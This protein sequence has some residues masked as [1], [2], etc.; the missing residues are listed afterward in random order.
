MDW[1]SVFSNKTPLEQ[2]EKIIDMNY[3]VLTERFKQY[4]FYVLSEFWGGKAYKQEAIK[5]KEKI[6]DVF[7]KYD[8]DYMES[9]K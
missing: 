7:T 5:T 6:S 8:Y 2:I 9:Y 3:P 4:I 1:H